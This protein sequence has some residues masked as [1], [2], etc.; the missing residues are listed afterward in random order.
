[1]ASNK[2]KREVTFELLDEDYKAFGRYRI[3]YTDQGHRLV[4]RQRI[5]YVF[6]G[7]MIALLFTI[8]KVDHSFTILAYVV[9]AAL[10]VV[11]LVFAEAM[12]LRQQ[13]KVIEN[14]AA[15]ADRVHAGENK[16]RFD[17]DSFTTYG[18]GDEQTFPYSDIKLIDLT[19]EGIYVW[20][21]DTMIMPIPLHAFRG[22]E[23]MKEL[24]KWVR[25][26][27]GVNQ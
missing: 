25:D 3:L 2:N 20:M 19:E 15:T 13:D 17:E 27:A 21:S 16:I 4:R 22:M 1:M 5:T 24:Y 10:V 26:K 12:V 14:S 7:V 23:E 18:G 9:A 11:G 6:S 8:F